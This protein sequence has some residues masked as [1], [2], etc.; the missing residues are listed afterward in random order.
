MKKQLHMTIGSLPQMIGSGTSPQLIVE[1]DL[2]MVKAALLYADQ[3]TL[4]SLG[5]SS[6]IEL[7]T[8]FDFAPDKRFDFIKNILS[9][10]PTDKNSQFIL[11]LINSLEQNKNPELNKQIQNFLD[12][13]WKNGQSFINGIL[14]ESGGYE[15]VNAVKSGLIKIYTFKNPVH[16]MALE[17]E[18]DSFFL[19]YVDVVGKSVSNPFTY[20]LF[21]ENTSDLIS[22]GIK[23]EVFPVNEYSINNA[24]EVA[25]ASDLLERL[26]TFPQATVKEILELRKE[27]KEHLTLFRSAVISF[28]EKIKNTSWDKNF[29]FDAEHVFR[30][31]IAP[32]IDRLEEEIKSNKFVKELLRKFAEKLPIAAAGST[33]AL[34]G[35]ALAMKMSDLSLPTIV[36]LSV[37]GLISGGISLY[38]THKEWNK[39]ERKT[40]ENNLFFYYRASKLLK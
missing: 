24:K 7:A 10:V 4:C 8:G 14:E 36:G 16:R 28:S 35:S 12:E 19:E 40:K 11:S 9:L 18:R 34:G 32:T 29:Q 6:L 3:A 1:N 22:K 23:A 27:L 2:Q 25:L 5:S 20:P 39:A 38:D 31:D 26:P 21:D 30:R 17:E 33:L 15:I 13:G 37:G